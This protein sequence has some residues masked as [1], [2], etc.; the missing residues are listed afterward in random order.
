MQRINRSAHAPVG[1]AVL[2]FLGL[3]IVP[4]SLRAAGVRISISPR[5]AAATDAWQQVA[6]VFGAS[7]H[8]APPAELSVVRDLNGGPSTIESSQC[9]RSGYFACAQE[10]RELPSTAVEA[11]DV[12]SLKSSPERR[13][14]PKPAARRSLSSH[15]VEIVIAAEAIKA[16][17]EKQAPALEALGA[18]RVSTFKRGELIKSLDKR[19]F[20]QT[21]RPI[22]EF[23]SP[24]DSENMKVFVHL[25]RAVAGSSAKSAERKVFS[26]LAS[27]RRRE[28]D[29]AILTGVPTDRLDH[30]E[31]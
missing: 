19:L 23:R 31:F 20:K 29:S 28:C 15:Q 11:S 17:I 3:A 1:T 9:T 10:P 2:L 16:S 27:A 5:L 13:S 21:F 8:P 18:L 12:L 14:A 4:V 30:S 25:R 6:E 7:Y 24:V 22:V 26:A